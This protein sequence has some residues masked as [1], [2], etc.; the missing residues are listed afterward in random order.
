MPT[1]KSIQLVVEDCTVRLGHF[2]PR[3][4][5]VRLAKNSRHVRHRACAAWRNRYSRFLASL[6]PACLLENFGQTETRP[7]SVTAGSGYPTRTRRP[8]HL[9]TIGWARQQRRDPRRP[10][11]CRARQ[12]RRV[13]SLFVSLHLSLL[14]PS[15]DAWARLCEWTDSFVS[16]FSLY[17]SPVASL[18]RKALSQPGCL[19]MIVC[20]WCVPADHIG[21]FQVTRFLAMLVSKSWRGLLRWALCGF[22]GCCSSYL[23]LEASP[24]VYLPS[25]D[26]ALICQIHTDGLQKIR[27]CR[28]SRARARR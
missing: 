27:R 6:T 26:V 7:A 10:P 8:Q 1:E 28:A 18:P 11:A 21:A 9:Q 23:V 5:E 14:S 25:S 3:T 13:H 19:A 4:C 24:H 2:C 16:L 22:Q 17:F 15:L 12:G 20:S